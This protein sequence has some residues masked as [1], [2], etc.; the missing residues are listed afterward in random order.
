MKNKIATV[1][2][3]FMF[4][5]IVG[6]VVSYCAPS[7]KAE[8]LCGRVVIGQSHLIGSYG[9]SP[10]PVVEL[11]EGNVYYSYVYPRLFEHVSECRV[12]VD[13]NGFVYN[14]EVIE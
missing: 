3:V 10:L 13:R 8:D 1:V 2:L 4:L 9:K 6:M 14:K 7:S 5:P 11:G 12:Y